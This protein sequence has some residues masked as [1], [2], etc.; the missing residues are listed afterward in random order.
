LHGGLFKKSTNRSWDSKITG[1]EYHKIFAR[2]N[3]RMELGDIMYSGKT[4]YR[5]ARTTE[6]VLSLE[7]INT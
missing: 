5:K 6:K 1:R 7:P 3:E 4:T 2:G